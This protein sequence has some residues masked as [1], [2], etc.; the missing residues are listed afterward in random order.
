MIWYTL[1]A[2]ADS[3][4]Q[5]TI[6]SSDSDEILDV[7]SGL[8]SEH[9]PDRCNS[10]TFHKRPARLATDASILADA[11]QE[12]L[13]TH[14]AL[15]RKFTHF[16]LLQPTSPVRKPGEID[17]LLVAGQKQG[18]KSMMAVA[19][20]TQHPGDIVRFGPDGMSF[21]LSRE[22]ETQR[23]Q[24]DEMY[25][26]VGSH[27]LVELEHFRK[28]GQVFDSTTERFQIDPEYSIDVD[29]LSDFRM[30]EAM[31]QYLGRGAVYS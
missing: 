3:Q 17:R 7:A 20:P 1:C 10:F 26:V 30:A 31:I 12:S 27:Y 22:R 21:L 23:Q 16:L 5:H 19:K 9:F 29:H 6:V 18:A 4:L 2:A 28:V 15:L 25:F 11:I 8:V 24:Y 14:A 13:E